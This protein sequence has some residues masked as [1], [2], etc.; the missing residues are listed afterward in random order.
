MARNFAEKETSL[1][2]ITRWLDTPKDA[3]GLFVGLPN[4]KPIEHHL[5]YYGE[6]H[7]EAYDYQARKKRLMEIHQ[8][9][10]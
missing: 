5:R 1:E 8:C 6:Y 4:Q 10:R 9:K 2:R 3:Y 7:R